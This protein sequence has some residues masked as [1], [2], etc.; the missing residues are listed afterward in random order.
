[1]SHR[2][3]THNYKIE[4]DYLLSKWEFDQ[5][6]QAIY[7]WLETYD[8]R[9]R[10]YL[11]HSLVKHAKITYESEGLKKL[12]LESLDYIMRNLRFIRR[13]W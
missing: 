7:A 12:L 10:D 13:R 5:Y 6:R 11:P 4:T 9:F 3:D 2:W 8:S 1:M